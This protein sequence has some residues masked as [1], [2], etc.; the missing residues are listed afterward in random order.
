MSRIRFDRLAPPRRSGDARRGARLGRRAGRRRA[1]AESPRRG[2]AGQAG[3]RSQ[4]RAR[5]RRPFRAFVAELWPLA[6]DRGVSRE[7]FDAAFRGVTFDPRIVAHTTA[8]AEFVQPIWVYLTNAVSARRIAR[9]RAKA[10]DVRPWLAK[11]EKSYGVDPA[12]LMGVWGM[13]SEFGVF[14]GGDSVVQALASLAFVRYQGDYFRDELM[15][16]LAILEEG[17][18][19]PRQ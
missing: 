15:A 14:T 10:D 19:R 11:A 6:K 3:R 9:G 12:V 2:V 5:L 8:Q 4:R 16:A 7:T 13:E 17:D 1:G 18:V